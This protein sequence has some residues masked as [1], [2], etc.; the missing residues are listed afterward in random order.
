MVDNRNLAQR[1][2]KA[3]RASVT[4]EIG[5]PGLFWFNEFVDIKRPIHDA[6]IADDIPEL[7]K[8]LE[9]PDKTNLFFGFDNLT[10]NFVRLRQPGDIERNRE[11]NRRLLFKLGMAF[12]NLRHFN[13]EQPRPDNPI[14]L[15]ELFEWI[16]AT[17]GF[18]VEFPSLS[19]AELGLETSR[20][21]VSERAVQAI[22]Q[23]WRVSGLCHDIEAP[24]I[25][26]IGAGLGRTA[27]YSW[28]KGLRDYTIVD[29]PMTAVAQAYFLGRLLG[30][31]CI[32]LYGESDGGSIRILPP[33]AFF[34]SQDC[35]DIAVNVDSLTEMAREVAEKYATNIQDRAGVFL[36]VNHEANPF[37]VRE[38]L[39]GE[40]AKLTQRNLYWMREGYVEEIVDFERPRRFQ[41]ITNQL[42]KIKKSF[43]WRAT[44]PLRSL[45]KR[46]SWSL[47]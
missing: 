40:A 21:L 16:D 8:M 6:L 33:Q 19:A 17:C 25:L 9:N 4:T 15:D 7:Q 14:S 3:Y 37:T 47:G 5:S 46:I 24:R 29:I 12:G 31:D 38:L 44:T 45:A 18:R 28:Q 43:S 10:L 34:D 42:T 30:E 27:Y 20:G 2:A 22:Y 11:W 39:S 13:P 41:E 1:I 36:S 35:Y 23:T 26:E 32:K